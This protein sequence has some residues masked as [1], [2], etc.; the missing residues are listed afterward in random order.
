MLTI[1][2]LSAGYGKLVVLYDINLTVE[3]AQFVAILGPNGSGK[4][5][6]LKTIFGMTYVVGGTIRFED[7]SLLGIPT[8][9]I[10]QH[11]I[12]YVPQR[13]NVFTTMTVRENLLLALRKLPRHE[14][15]PLLQ[16][17]FALFPI[18][19]ERQAQRAGR[20]SGGERQMLAIAIGWLA[21]PRLMLL[22]EPSAGLS[23]RMVSEVFRTLQTLAQSGITLI[24][25]EQNARSL[26]RWC[27]YAYILREGQI[28]F[29]GATAEIL[30]D[31]ETV[32]GYLGV[33]T[34]GR[35][36]E[37]ATSREGDKE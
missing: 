5:T 36:G 16:K 35:H 23:P 1:T 26:L 31:E 34:R 24:V 13:E 22:D 19:E 15:D 28:A 10:G 14:A 25:V 18:L 33:V 32:K 29:Q 6:L 2:H 21:Q 27:D 17:A 8:E 30:A 7:R 3:P 37:R 11:G 4:S 20:M 12:A 9:A